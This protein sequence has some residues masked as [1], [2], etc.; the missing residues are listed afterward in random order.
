VRIARIA[1]DQLVLE[2]RT[3]DAGRIAIS[4][5][6]VLI[7]RREDGSFPLRAILTPSG[8]TD[9]GFVITTDE[10]AITGGD[11]RFI[12]RTTTPLFS[13]EITRLSATLRDVSSDEQ[14]RA[15]LIVQGIVGGGAALDLRGEVAPFATPFFLEVAGELKGLAGQRTTEVHYR[16]VGDEVTANK[17][18][19]L[20][21]LDAASSRGRDQAE[22]MVGV[23]LGLVVALLTDARGDIR[24]ARALGGE[25]GP[26]RASFGETFRSALK[27]LV[28]GPVQLISRLFRQD[29]N[30]TDPDPVVFDPGSA[31]LTLEAGK[32]LRRVAEMLRASP[33]VELVLAPVVSARDVAALRRQEVTARIQELQRRERL[34]DIEEAAQRLFHLT[35]PGE[36]PPR[37][38]EAIVRALAARMPPPAEEAGVLAERRVGVVRSFLVDGAG[39]A[40]GRLSEDASAAGGGGGDGRVKLGLKPAS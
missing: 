8:A 17:E 24:I 25:P 4:R 11:L 39:I 18:L 38:L 28:R 26:P 34:D 40:P 16:V 22:R 20:H 36:E 5:P 13:E 32:H 33:H 1:I 30:A 21:R 7:E 31:A 19:V 10:I 3:V 12:D 23:P 35:F 6:S 29:G 15:G 14:H 37:G 2:G 27:S 9:A